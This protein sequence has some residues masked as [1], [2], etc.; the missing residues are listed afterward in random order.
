LRTGGASGVE[1]TGGPASGTEATRPILADLL[2]SVLNPPPGHRLR[3]LELLNPFN[4]KEA[5]DDKL[6]ILDI[7][8]RDETGR[9]FNIEMQM[10]P[11]RYYAQRIVYYACKLHQQQLHEADDYV[12]LR[13]TISISF[14]N[15]VWF[16]QPA[17]PHL[18]FRL[19]E[20][21]H[22]FALAD[23]LE[24]HV[25]QLPKFT[26]PA[27]ALAGNL[28]NWLYFL[29]H[30]EMMDMD[31]V[32]APLQAQPLVLRALEE[33]QMLARSDLERERY[34]ARRKAQLDQN[35][36]MKVAHMEGREEG[37]EEGMKI[38]IIHL[39]EQLLRQPETPRE[40]LAALP[41]EEL[42]R[43]ANELQ[44]QVLKSRP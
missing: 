25:L 11:S 41:L 29:R 19:Y 23:D 5:L 42:T 31:A 14:L 4:P 6:S 22:G 27:E 2:E 17:E 15:Y 24:F 40:V 32:P 3:E 9:Q 44:Q 35:T 38:G 21:A 16:P 18:R 13:P 7:K 28:D 30:A 26:K 43:R 20:P 1:S 39:C 34:E 33:L 36:M 37:Q 8:A 10:Q 12:V